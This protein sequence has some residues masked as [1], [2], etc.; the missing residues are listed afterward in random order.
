MME[1]DEM[2]YTA[3]F[4]DK[5]GNLSRSRYTGVIARQEAWRRA[6]SMGESSNMCLLALVPGDHPVYTYENVFNSEQPSTELKQH[7]VFEMQANDAYEM[8]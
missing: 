2:I 7:D 5:D 4:Q 8:T 3:I 1:N 6:A